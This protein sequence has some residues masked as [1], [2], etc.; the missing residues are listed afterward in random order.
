MILIFFVADPRT[1]FLLTRMIKTLIKP[2][3]KLKTMHINEAKQLASKLEPGT[4]KA[5]FDTKPHI[6]FF[7]IL[8]NWMIILL[9]IGFCIQ[10]PNVWMYILSITIIGAR[11]HALAI[12][13]HDATH[14][15]FLKNRKWNDLLSNYLTMYPLFLSIE[16][17]RNNHLK[18]HQHLNTDNDPDW[19]AKLG[20]REFTF[21]KTRGEFLWTLGSYLVLYQGIMDAIWFIKRFS[22]DKDKA[23]PDAKNKAWK[24]TF[25]VLLASTLT[26]FG[27]WIYFLLFWMVPYLSTFFMFQYIRS[28]AEHFGE[29]DYEDDLSSTR[30]VKANW[31]EQFFLSP[32]NVGYHLEHHLYPGVPFYHLPKLHEM[33]MQQ[34]DFKNR[35][36]ITKGYM[37]GL[38]QELNI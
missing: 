3:K 5:L 37:K 16:V 17:Y 38:M 32:H 31:L 7:A 18:H 34:A 10:I 20:K 4:F 22:V 14:Y 13:V 19:I 15:R 2:L 8:F 1:K 6:H 30:T 11:M 12:L 21:P 29:L 25:Y 28:V 9:A 26:I 35:A 23:S 36:H 24:I 27:G 33:L